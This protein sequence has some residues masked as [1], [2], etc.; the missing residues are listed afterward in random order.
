M[1]S[2]STTLQTPHAP[3]TLFFLCG[4]HHPRF[5]KAR[6]L[7]AHP[8]RKRRAK[9]DELKIHALQAPDSCLRVTGPNCQGATFSSQ[10]ACK[11]S[12]AHTY[13]NNIGEEGEKGYQA[14][15]ELCL[16]KE[17]HYL[18]HFL[19]ALSLSVITQ[20]SQPYLPGC[21]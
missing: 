12:W 16:S 13:P 10:R 19:H 6:A 14:C 9:G 5:K 11:L 17:F 20:L 3:G 1:C 2:P 15:K 7:P 21:A 18:G 8:G 4:T